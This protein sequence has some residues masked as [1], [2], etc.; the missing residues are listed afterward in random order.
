MSGSSTAGEPADGLLARFR[1]RAEGVGSVA[2][3]CSGWAEAAQVAVDIADGAPIVMGPRTAEAPELRAAL[4]A[5]SG[6]AVIFVDPD[7]PLA[8]AVD[9]PVGVAV[10]EL[11]V[12]ETGSVMADETELADRAVSMLSQ[13]LVQFVAADRVVA[14]L[15]DVAEWLTTAASAAPGYRSLISGPSRT[16]DIERSLTVGVQGPSEVYVVVVG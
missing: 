8:A 11:G 5:A 7:D 1:E 10:G 6:P 13:T 2:H 14:S 16:A 15:D 3:A 12:A 4:E 9:A